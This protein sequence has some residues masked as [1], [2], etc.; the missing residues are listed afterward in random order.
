VFRRGL[1]L[2][3][4]PNTEKVR[5]HRLEGGNTPALLAVIAE[6]RTRATVKL[7]SSADMVC[8]SKAGRD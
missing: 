8:C 3:A 1:L 6:L 7:G 4:L 2:H 5:L